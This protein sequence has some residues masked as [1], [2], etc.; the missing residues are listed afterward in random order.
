M[1]SSAKG[2]TEEDSATQF[3]LIIQEQEDLKMGKAFAGLGLG[4]TRPSSHTELWKVVSD[5]ARLPQFV[6]GFQ[7]EIEKRINTLAG[8]AAWQCPLPRRAGGA[9]VPWRWGIARAYVGR[10]MPLQ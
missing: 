8:P 9:S 3:A 7:E 2:I 5:P 4:N 10:A 1:N 6:T